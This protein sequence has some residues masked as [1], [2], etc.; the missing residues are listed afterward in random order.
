[1]NTTFG[2][3]PATAD[4]KLPETA[5]AIPAD[6]RIRVIKIMEERE[7]YPKRWEDGWE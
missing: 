7:Q 6:S 1:M 5:N 2:S 3:A 4:V